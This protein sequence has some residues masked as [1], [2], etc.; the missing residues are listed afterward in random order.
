MAIALGGAVS[1]CLES[2]LAVGLS[3][4]SRGGALDPTVEGELLGL[5]AQPLAGE[6]APDIHA[7]V[8]RLVTVFRAIPRGARPSLADRLATPKAGDRLAHAFRSHLPAS[9]Q[10]RL[11]RALRRDVLA[12]PV[13]HDAFVAHLPSDPFQIEPSPLVVHPRIAPQVTAYVSL[14][15][16]HGPPSDAPPVHAVVR[17]FDEDGVAWAVA[18]VPWPRAM[19]ASTAAVFTFD[20]AGSY[21]IETELVQRGLV[22]AQRHGV[23]EVIQPGIEIVKRAG[24]QAAAEVEGP[25]PFMPWAFAAVY[26][27]L[28]EGGVEAD[29]A[30]VMVMSPAQR[31]DA[32]ARIT[33]DLAEDMDPAARAIL[34]SDRNLLEFAA[35]SAT[36]GA[37]RIERPAAPPAE[38]ITLAGTDHPAIEV[39]ADPP[40][41]RRWV[42]RTFL[43]DGISGVEALPEL[44]VDRAADDFGITR[45]PAHQAF[46]MQ[47]VIPELELQI[48][49]FKLEIDAFE[50]QFG[51]AATQVVIDVLDESERVA[52]AEQARCGID[53]ATTYD[54]TDL[55]LA[56]IAATREA[57]GGRLNMW[58][59]PRVVQLT[60]ARLHVAPGTL[61][62][63][64]IEHKVAT[65]REG[66][67]DAQAIAA[68]SFGLANRA[69]IATSGSRLAAATIVTMSD[70]GVATD[71]HLLLDRVRAYQLD[72][73]KV[74]AD[75]DA[76]ARAILRE[77]PLLFWSAFELIATGVDFSA[78]TKSFGVIAKALAKA[79]PV[80][81][82]GAR[83]PS[84]LA[85]LS[86]ARIRRLVR[87]GK[88]N[89]DA[90]EHIWHKIR[91]AAEGEDI[92]E[93]ATQASHIGSD[94]ARDAGRAGDV[95]DQPQGRLHRRARVSRENLARLELRLG[96]PLLIHDALSNAELHYIKK[97]GRVGLGTDIEPTGIAIGRNALIKDVL[98]HRTTLAHVT[99]YNTV[100]AKLRAL[101]EDLLVETSGVNSF[102]RGSG[103]WAAFEELRKLDE[104][105]E[106]RRARWDP[107]ILD[108]QILRDEIAFLGG[109][110]ECL[111][112]R[113]CSALS[114]SD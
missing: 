92:E 51:A 54:R 6:D 32:H 71:T 72:A 7:G 90:V 79:E 15:S 16:D 100:V 1:S 27:A 96:V 97:R 50:H 39:S 87:E 9:T 48:Q 70:A 62:S 37:Q 67:W 40:F 77:R 42:E 17:V 3:L 55:A 101:W 66:S 49:N 18:R 11:L 8:G 85:D 30:T 52:R 113:I 68:L 35:A 44:V 60:M 22:I 2:M 34:A 63:A 93:C 13:A 47:Q 109:R 28:L 36:G 74:G 23:V 108:A 38:Q 111:E 107:N 88:I 57:L 112:G 53:A 114:P 58:K 46:A 24:L 103:G 83:L 95:E 4:R 86:L 43:A 20:R 82:A 69:A 14:V 10:A 80:A 81:A 98:A 12:L 75:L 105:I 25:G 26:L 104:L 73:A 29:L 84:D 106:L 89:A 110:Y 64:M 31:R 76:Q 99:K 94:R 91:L 59:E 56:N 78:A 33:D 41:L 19:P 45:D 65:E 61:R 21:R 102:P 5:L